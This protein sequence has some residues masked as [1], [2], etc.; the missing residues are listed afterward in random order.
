MSSCPSWSCCRP[1]N[2]PRLP[3]GG[4]QGGV[5]VAGPAGAVPADDRRP[6]RPDVPQLRLTQ[7]TGSP[8]RNLNQQ[9]LCQ[10]PSSGGLFCSKN[11][12]WQVTCH[13]TPGQRSRCSRLV[14]EMQKCSCVNGGGPPQPPESTPLPGPQVGVTASG[15]GLRGLSLRH[16]SP[17]WSAGARLSLW[18]VL[19][20][21]VSVGQ[22]GI[23]TAAHSSLL[24]QPPALAMGGS[25]PPSPGQSRLLLPPHVL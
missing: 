7:C 23:C 5:G 6:Q 21:L 1:A 3:A 12:S 17:L 8:N 24:G 14:S 22:G 20:S 15:S 19:M 4:W 9:L 13:V 25:P 18:S 10:L 2:M 16:V 11:V